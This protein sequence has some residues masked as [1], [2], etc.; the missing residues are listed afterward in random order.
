MRC[1]ADPYLRGPAGQAETRDGAW[2]RADHERRAHD[3]RALER[4][5]REPLDAICRDARCCGSGVVE[6][7]DAKKCSPEKDCA[8]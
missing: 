5:S 3:R 6:N 4:L 8:A 7:Q 2:R 1:V